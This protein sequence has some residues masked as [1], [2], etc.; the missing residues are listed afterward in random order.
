ML[1]EKDYCWVVFCKN[2][3]FHLRQNLLFRYR[4]PLGITDDVAPVPKLK[5]GQFAAKC[6]EC[7]KEYLYAPEDVRRS[8]LKVPERFTPHPCFW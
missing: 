1:E 7:R 6:D 5:T 8:A 2:R 4:I 3:W